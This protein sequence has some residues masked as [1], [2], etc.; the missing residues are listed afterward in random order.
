MVYVL[1]APGHV[2]PHNINKDNLKSVNGFSCELWSSGWK[3]IAT[4]GA[5][6]KDDVKEWKVQVEN[7]GTMQIGRDRQ[8]WTVQ[9]PAELTMG[10]GAL[11]LVVETT[12]RTPWTTRSLISGPEGQRHL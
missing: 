3:H 1:Y 11:E 9:M 5:N 7:V 6:A 10:N 12:Q 4:Q 8:S 2:P